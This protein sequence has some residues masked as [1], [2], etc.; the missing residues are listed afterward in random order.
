MVSDFLAMTETGEFPPIWSDL[1]LRAVDD[2]DEDLDE[3][4]DFD[5]EDLDEE[6]DF[7]DEDLGDEDLDEEDDEDLDDE[8]LDEE[9]E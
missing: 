4:D 1:R 6:E 2:D 3:E 8:D 5:D 7:D 9:E